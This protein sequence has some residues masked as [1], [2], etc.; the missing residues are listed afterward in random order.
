M[1]VLNTQDNSWYLASNRNFLY[2][3]YPEDYDFSD[4]AWQVYTMQGALAA[5]HRA[6]DNYYHINARQLDTYFYRGAD[7]RPSEVPTAP[8]LTVQTYTHAEALFNAHETFVPSTVSHTYAVNSTWLGPLSTALAANNITLQEALDGDDALPMPALHTFFRGL[9]GMTLTLPLQSF[10]FGTLYRTCVDWEV[11]VQYKFSDRG[12]LQLLMVNNVVGTCNEYPSAVQRLGD[13][14]LW[15]N[16]VILVLAT[17]HLLLLLRA[18]YRTYTIA[19]EFA[20]LSKDSTPQRSPVQWLWQAATPCCR[21]PPDATPPRRRSMR[22]PLLVD[23]STG[24]AAGRKRKHRRRHAPEDSSSS[25]D[26]EH[27]AALSRDPLIR[28]AIAL[29]Q[30]PDSYFTNDLSGGG[31]LIHCNGVTVPMPPQLLQQAARRPDTADDIL[32]S[33]S[34]RS[35]RASSDVT[36]IARG[37]GGEGKASLNRDGSDRVLLPKLRTPTRTRVATDDTDLYSPAGRASTALKW[38]AGQEGGPEGEEG[39]PS[40]S[41]DG[42]TSTDMAEDLGLDWNSIPWSS[43]VVLFNRWSILSFIASICNIVACVLNLTGSVAHAPTSPFHSLMIAFGC[44]LLWVSLVRYLEHNPHYYSL[45]LTLRKGIPRV[46]RFLLGVL[47]VFMA[48]TMFSVVYFA[49]TAPRF[50]DVATAAVT[51]FAVLNGDVVRETFMTL[52]EFHPVMGQV[53]MYVFVSLFIYVVLNI[54]IAVIEESFYSTAEQSEKLLQQQAE[55]RRAGQAASTG[56]SVAGSTAAQQPASAMPVSTP[57]PA[58]DIGSPVAPG[59]PPGGPAAAAA[60]GP[61]LAA[62]EAGLIRRSVSHGPALQSSSKKAKQARREARQRKK[63]SLLKQ[64]AK[65]D[66]HAL[67]LNPDDPLGRFFLGADAVEAMRR[68]SEEAPKRKPARKGPK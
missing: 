35:D 59:T 40:S 14:L 32:R 47:P 2:L 11:V 23:A 65:P 6:V 21:A 17:A 54:L 7:G 18:V 45:V 44:S 55:M 42:S 38:M 3:F 27:V 50:G 8:H 19:G 51:L 66:L 37:D 48:F 60:G 24:A 12:Q 30:H 25:S 15:L 57:A 16:V 9:H 22:E 52:M 1:I 28:Q 53:F 31:A 5:V 41:S 33:T 39:G 46:M 10:G 68:N 63:E 4:P 43:K 49:A 58:A 20:A 34:V 62:D 64:A 29:I 26:D 13:R 67:A 36:G 56:G 61:A